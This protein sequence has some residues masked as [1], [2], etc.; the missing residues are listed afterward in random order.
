M[1]DMAGDTNN[2]P[3][4]LVPAS[5]LG[6]RLAFLLALALILLVL[7][8]WMT[9]SLLDATGGLTIDPLTFTATNLDEISVILPRLL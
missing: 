3:P 8:V 5:S 1:T 2:S 4:E 6:R 9:V 7:L